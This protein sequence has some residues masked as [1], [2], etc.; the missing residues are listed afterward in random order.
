MKVPKLNVAVSSLLPPDSAVMQFS[1]N[2]AYLPGFTENATLPFQPGK[3]YRLRIINM[4]ALGEF[5]SY[6]TSLAPDCRA[7][8]LRA[9]AAM[10]AFWIDGHDM[11]VIEVDGT[12]VAEYPIDLVTISVAQRVSVLVTA[13]NETNTNYMIHANMV[14]TVQTV[15]PCSLCLFAEGY[16]H[17]VL[18]WLYDL[19]TT[20]SRHV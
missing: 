15:A 10:F 3:T 6:A 2:S 16:A 1:Q 7:N 9:M 4:S 18:I 20:E 5:D 13:R 19:E 8:N 14:S 12:D 17:H 11:R